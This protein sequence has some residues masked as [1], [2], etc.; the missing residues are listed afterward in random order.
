[1]TSVAPFAAWA[2][3]NLSTQHTPAAGPHNRDIYGHR[4]PI[5]CHNMSVARMSKKP[6]FCVTI[7]LF[8]IDGS[9]FNVNTSANPTFMNVALA[10]FQADHIA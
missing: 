1:L 10:N 9:F 6:K 4:A 7:H 2:G 5:D 8:V 3:R